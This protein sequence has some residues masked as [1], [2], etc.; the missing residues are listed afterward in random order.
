[1][2]YNPKQ[3]TATLYLLKEEIESSGYVKFYDITSNPSGEGDLV[4]YAAAQNINDNPSFG[5]NYKFSTTWTVS[6]CEEKLYRWVSYDR[7][8]NAGTEGTYNIE[9]AL[10]P[11]TPTLS[12]AVRTD[13]TLTFSIG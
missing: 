1:M 7:Y 6:E 3:I 5:D 8:G 11:T 10:T 2:N 12:N 9:V 13:N 4:A